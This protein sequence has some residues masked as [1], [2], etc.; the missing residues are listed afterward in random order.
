MPGGFEDKIDNLFEED[1][2]SLKQ[3]QAKATMDAW[4]E[5][6]AQN[7]AVER[8][9]NKLEQTNPEAANA[10]FAHLV[11][12][13]TSVLEEKGRNPDRGGSESNDKKNEDH[14]EGMSMDFVADSLIGH[15]VETHGDP[16]ESFGG[17]GGGKPGGDTASSAGWMSDNDDYGGGDG[18]GDGEGEDGEG[19]EGGGDKPDKGKGKDESAK[20]SSQTSKKDEGGGRAARDKGK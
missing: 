17:G 15:G 5:T 20:A 4:Q 14:S 10:L 18:E 8:M 9:I 3:E 11:D 2:G 13:A 16:T 19:G 6:Q 7:P 1:K 12:R